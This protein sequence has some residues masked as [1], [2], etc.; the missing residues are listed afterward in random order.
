VVL[1]IPRWYFRL[2]VVFQIIKVAI[3]IPVEL[4]WAESRD[5]A[6]ERDEGTGGRAIGQ[7]RRPRQVGP[8]LPLC[9]LDIGS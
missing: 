8:L 1:Q 2:P 5:Q 9:L 4:G 6:R 3:I 7:G